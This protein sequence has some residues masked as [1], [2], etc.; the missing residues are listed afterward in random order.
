MPYRFP[1]FFSKPV[2]CPKPESKDEVCEEKKPFSR[3]LG[4]MS[5]ETPKRKTNPWNI[6]SKDS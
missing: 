4:D 5:P 6:F 2:V 3:P 1:F